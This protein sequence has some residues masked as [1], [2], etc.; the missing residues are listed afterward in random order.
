M[1]RG[2]PNPADPTRWVQRLRDKCRREALEIRLRSTAQAEAETAQV[3]AAT[4]AVITKRIAQLRDLR[5][6]LAESS[7]RVERDLVRTA[8]E[9]RRRI[10]SGE[11]A[12]EAAIPGSGVT[13]P[14]AR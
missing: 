2:N 3:V 8:V 9:L 11:G 12:G 1:T 10:E 14:P 5:D 4:N 13:Y 6:E 7:A